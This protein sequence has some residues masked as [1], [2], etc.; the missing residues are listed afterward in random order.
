MTKGISRHP[1]GRLLFYAVKGLAIRQRMASPPWPSPAALI[2]RGETRTVTMTGKR[3]INRDYDPR[4]SDK[5]VD[6]VQRFKPHVSKRWT[7]GNIR[8]RDSKGYSKARGESGSWGHLY[9]NAR[10]RRRRKIFMQ[11]HP[12]C[13]CGEL[14]TD[15]DHI[16]PHKGDRKLFF[17]ESNWQALCKSCHS[18]KT[19]AEDGGFGNE[20]RGAVKKI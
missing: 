1:R 16:V 12:L 7:C 14:A 17:D 20:T 11:N 19:A 10:Y 9:G 2:V 18:R 15:L 3:T 6:Y 8:E 13:P 4:S 5:Q